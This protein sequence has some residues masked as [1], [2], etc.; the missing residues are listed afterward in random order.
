MI[1]RGARAAAPETRCRRLRE[2]LGLSRVEWARALNVQEITVKRW[3]DQGIEPGGSAEE[4][5]CGIEAALAQGIS[6]DRIGALVNLGG[7][8]S[9]I[10]YALGKRLGPVP[11]V[12]VKAKNGHNG[13]RRHR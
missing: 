13:E 1:T 10:C 9:L 2:Q 8:R 5:I 3:E 4:I 6:P 7:I 11:E 12:K